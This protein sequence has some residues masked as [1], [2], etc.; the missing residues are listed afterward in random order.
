MESM[1]YHNVVSKQTHLFRE[2]YDQKMTNY[3]HLYAMSNY[4]HVCYCTKV[5]KI[6]NL[7]ISNIAK[8]LNSNGLASFLCITSLHSQC[9]CVCL[10]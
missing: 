5:H 1:K 4:L 3:I 7:I 9:D 2:H 6:Y 8:V 10:T